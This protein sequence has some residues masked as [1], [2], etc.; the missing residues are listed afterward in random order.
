MPPSTVDTV[1][2]ILLPHSGATAATRVAAEVEEMAVSIAAIVGRGLNDRRGS[3]SITMNTTNRMTTIAKDDPDPLAIDKA[4]T[5]TPLT[6]HNHLDVPPPHEILMGN[7]MT[8]VTDANPAIESLMLN[9]MRVQHGK[10][11]VS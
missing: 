4:A 5:S 6:D 1:A 9:N 3:A 7:T 2:T 10:R 8:T 11:Q